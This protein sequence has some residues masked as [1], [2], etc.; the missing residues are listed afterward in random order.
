[1]PATMTTPTTK[2]W[3]TDWMGAPDAQTH[4]RVRDNESTMYGVPGA[5]E[6]FLAY[7]LLFAK[8]VRSIFRA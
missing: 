3:R 6:K 1:M 4:E 8:G 7:A 5:N 2:K